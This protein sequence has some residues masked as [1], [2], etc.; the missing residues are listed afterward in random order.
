MKTAE[1]VHTINADTRSV[2]AFVFA[3]S[4]EGWHGGKNYYR[5]L[6]ESLYSDQERGVDVCAFVGKRIDVSGFGFPV[7]VKI[8]R[9]SALD[10]GSLPW[11]V[12][13]VF[14]KLFGYSWFMRKYMKV[15]KVDAVS[16]SE[17]MYSKGFP[18]I[19]WIPDFQHIHLP[20][21]F[22]KQEVEQRNAKFRE[23]INKSDAVILS[24]NSAKLDLAK[25]MPEGK[26]K[27]A[28]LRFCSI[29]P[30]ILED[31]AN[32]VRSEYNLASPYFYLPNQF[33]AHKNHE[34]VLKALFSLKKDF[35]KIRVL[36]SGAL[37]DYRNP[38]HVEKIK[39]LIKNFDLSNNFIL[40]GVVPYNHI[41][42]LMLNS[43][44]VINPSF[45]EGWSTT[46]EEAKALGVP[47]LLSDISVHREQCSAHGADFFNP[48]NSD[49]LVQCMKKLLNAQ[50]TLL[51]KSSLLVTAIEAHR[52]Q[53]IAFA[54]TYQNIVQN[55]L[56]SNKVGERE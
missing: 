20:N 56:T 14:A 27:A 50:N 49:D 15:N 44:A 31:D 22:D 17:L 45:F 46:V 53:M 25:F 33:W 40:L 28:V 23:I 37:N 24:S 52:L 4:G 26:H 32:F 8:V 42:H 12:D 9:T 55:V 34:V 39:E 16:H 29:K 18:T 54:R 36:A 47:L 5:S 11:F 41:S 21:F 38:D 2:V 30:S 43:I 48:D 51:N 6:L 7:D 10:R 13:K 1:V 19:S 35:P 3:G